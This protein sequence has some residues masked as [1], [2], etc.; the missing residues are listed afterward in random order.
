MNPRW[1]N[2]NAGAVV[3]AVITAKSAVA[4]AAAVSLICFLSI[5]V[6]LVRYK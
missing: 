3:A 2:Q 4:G 5:F 1:T 6:R